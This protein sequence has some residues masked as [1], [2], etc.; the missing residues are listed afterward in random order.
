VALV[1]LSAVSVLL[2]VVPAAQ[3]AG[4]A[5]AWS[6]DGGVVPPGDDLVVCPMV[7]DFESSQTL[8]V[9]VLDGGTWVDKQTYG[10]SSQNWCFEFD[11][12]A[13][14]PGPGTYSFRASSRL[15]ST[16][17]LATTEVGAF[18]LG[19]DDGR[20]AWLDS[21]DFWASDEW[22]GAGLRLST[23]SAGSRVTRVQI[24][25]AHGQV[26]ELQRRS[27]SSW[28][29]VAQVQAPPTGDDVTV[30]LTFP[31][32][33]G[34]STHRFVSRA[35]AWSP[36]VVT[37]SFTVYQ[38]AARNRASYIAEARHYMAKYCPKT[39]ISIDTRAVRSGAVLGRASASSGG[40]GRRKFLVT[41]IEL[42]S[43]MPPD[44]LRAVALHE[45]GHIV[46]YRAIVKGRYGDVSRQA[47]KLW[48]GLGVEGQADCMSYQVTR[49]YHWFGYVRGC[50]TAQLVNAAKLWQTYGGKYQAASYRW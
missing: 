18:T 1:V 11:P 44:Q 27:G 26:V 24:A 39:P 19:A 5:I 14:V 38:T 20:I 49:D 17:E 45:C 3:A 21:G 10:R 2:G 50:S 13:L 31:A 6:Q 22:M 28:L 30:Q 4:F 47:A 46:Q 32:R 33:A 35:T 41:K 34:M 9:Q 29:A 23:V 43:G 40:S 12:T 36:T 8:L 16:G 15:P 42:R 48:P 25:R 7:S 37:G